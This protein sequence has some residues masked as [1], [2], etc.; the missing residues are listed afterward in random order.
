MGLFREGSLNEG[1]IL[2]SGSSKNHA[3]YPRIEKT[4]DNGHASNST[5][6]LDFCVRN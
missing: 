4:F 3:L 6:N 2:N 1:L 5:A